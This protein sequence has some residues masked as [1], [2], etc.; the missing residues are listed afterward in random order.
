[1]TV[2]GDPVFPD[3]HLKGESGITVRDYFAIKIFAELM[4]NTD[5]RFDEDCEEAYSLADKLIK[6]GNA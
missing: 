2:K 6:A 4:K 5:T 1:M 3:P